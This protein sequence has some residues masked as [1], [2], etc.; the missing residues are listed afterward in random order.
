MKKKNAR[1]FRIRRIV[2]IIIIVII[3]L[4]IKNLIYNFSVKNSQKQMRLL[5][6]N[7]L[8][9]LSN[10]LYVEE[11]NIYMSE[12]DVQNIFDSTI[13]YNVGDKELITTYNRHVAVLH[14]DETQMIVNDSALE[15]KGKLKEIEG[16]IYLPISDLGIV[17]DVETEYAKETNCVI[18]NATTKAKKQVMA[19]NNA[20]IRLRKN[21]FSVTVEKVKRGDYLYVIEE[22]GNDKKVR[23]A[24]RQY[25]IHKK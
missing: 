11:E 21:P 10:S 3:I 15:M 1:K 12:E 18:M 16:K 19:L 6:N 23:T 22:S 17:Y 5:L 2:A 13:Y 20:K 4:G 8:V 9:S 14:L 25:W 24:S 7:E